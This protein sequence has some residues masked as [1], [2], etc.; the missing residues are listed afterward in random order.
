MRF[1]L[2]ACLPLVVF[3]DGAFGG[4]CRP[5]AEEA[6]AWRRHCESQPLRFLDRWPEACGAA[7]ASH[8]AAPRHSSSA[9]AGRHAHAA[10][11]PSPSLAPCRLAAQSA[12]RCGHHNTRSPPSKSRCTTLQVSSFVCMCVHV[13]C[14]CRRELFPQ[15]VRVMREMGDFIGADPR[16][17]HT[18]GAEGSAAGERSGTDAASACAHA[19]VPY[20]F[21]LLSCPPSPPGPGVPA[22]RHH[23]PQHRHP[24]RGCAWAAWPEG[25]RGAP[26]QRAALHKGVG[27]G[28]RGAVGSASKGR[29]GEGEVVTSYG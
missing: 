10:Q 19:S 21:A 5:A 18:T 27:G 12:G 23:G 9:P 8:P 26:Q 25:R 1:S 11:R 17:G 4:V 14:P 29:E 24:G 3:T 28:A 15:L 22:Q 13:S 6:D 7:A 20:P 16:V 2:P